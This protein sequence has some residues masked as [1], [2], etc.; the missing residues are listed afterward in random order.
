M[1]A[2]VMYTY[3][4]TGIVSSSWFVQLRADVS[5]C[6]NF[7]QS[8]MIRCHTWKMD[9]ECCKGISKRYSVVLIRLFKLRLPDGYLQSHRNT[10]E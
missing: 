1:I 8:A 4:T 2:V 5:P 9:Q 10:S 3:N 7:S 6:G